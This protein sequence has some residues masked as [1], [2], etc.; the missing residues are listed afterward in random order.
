MDVPAPFFI[1]L[2]PEIFYNIAQYI[3]VVGFGAIFLSCK[4]AVAK[5]G[6]DLRLQKIVC[7]NTT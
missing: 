2:P 7:D 5:L 4:E 3:D 1:L 6:S